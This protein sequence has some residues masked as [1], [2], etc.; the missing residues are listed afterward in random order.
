MAD[1]EFESCDFMLISGFPCLRAFSDLRMVLK[2][3]LL[4]IL[5]DSHSCLLLL[6]LDRSLPRRQSMKLVA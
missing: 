3:Q 6:L 2:H 4:V 1:V 5:Q